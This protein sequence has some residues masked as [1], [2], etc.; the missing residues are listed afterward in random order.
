MAVIKEK[1]EFCTLM[2]DELYGQLPARVY[3]TLF[4]RGKLSIRLITQFSKLNARQVKNGLCVLQQHNLLFYTVDANSGEAEY[5]VNHESAYNLVRA[6]KI[7]EMVD[8]SYGPAG[9]DV[10]QNLLLLGQ[11]RV[12]DLVAAY[13][14]KINLANDEDAWLDDKKPE[15]V[16]KSK[17]QL[18]SVLCRLIEAELVDVIHSKTFQS[19]HEIEKQV[20]KEVMDVYFPNG[21]KGTKAKVEF[22]QKVAEGL[23][24]VREESK[25]LKRKLAQNGGASK[26]RKLAV[27]NE[28]NGAPEEEEDLD[29]ALDPRQVI[30][31]NYEKCIVELRSRRLVQ[32]VSETIGEM[33]AYVYGQV[34]KQLTKNISR[35]R[36]DP[37]MDSLTLEE[38]KETP[39]VTTNEILD[40]VKTSVDLTLGI[41]KIPGKSISKSAAERLI[42]FAPKDK[43]PFMSQE[44][45]DDDD[46]DGD[47]S[48]SDEEMDTK[49]ENGDAPVARMSRPEQLRQH[50]LLLAE[51]QPG[52]VR[53]CGEDEWTVD[54]KPLM[55]NLRATELDSIIEQTCGRQG[56][57]LTRI[58][59]TKG[60]LGEQALQSLSLMRKVDLQQKMLEMR[61]A[62]FAHTQEV[63]RDNKADPKKSIFLWYCDTEQAYSG[64]I[65][66]CYAT[67]VHCLQVLEVRRQKEKAVLSLAKRTNVK[68]KEKD[69]MRDE[70]YARFAKFLKDEKLLMAEVMRIDDTLALLQ[71]F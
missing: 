2:V 65:A 33:T 36:P 34:L 56:L 14:A 5:S 21:I 26:R 32:Y 22:E 15:L 31:I 54:F 68:G 51:S 1:A 40:K 25:T 64:L 61:L 41:G 53:H 48:D 42:P 24:K 7:L 57:R 8:N 16:I 30:R 66:K 52:F 9:R 38:A 12:S 29:P 23:R 18:N 60:K 4:Q 44:D 35:C 69:M 10:M 55:E 11:T 63:P 62:G 50:L 47:Y 19:A 20:H 17:A 58:L 71:D 6:G 13:Q 46:E 59:R 28:T 43:I 70:S 27:G 67:M 39:S 45:S 3:A 49:K 37:L